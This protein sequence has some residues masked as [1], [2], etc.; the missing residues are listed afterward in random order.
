M[1]FQPAGGV[2]CNV[3]LDGERAKEFFN[4]FF[5]KSGEPSD[6]TMFH[7]ETITDGH[8]DPSSSWDGFFLNSEEKNFFIE[9]PKTMSPCSK[10]ALMSLLEVAE[11]MNGSKVFVCVDKN[12]ADL[13]ALVHALMYLGFSLVT[14][15]VRAQVI[16]SKAE[17]FLVLG[18]DLE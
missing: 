4:S 10:D 17:D 7:V 9:A 15:T 14:E 18:F 8:S 6:A 1:G 3:S 12:H 13:K 5:G 2:E 16:K 11:E